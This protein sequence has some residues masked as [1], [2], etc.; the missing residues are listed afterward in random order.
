LI[1]SSLARA[2]LLAV[3][4][5]ENDNDPQPHPCFCVTRVGTWR[6]LGGDWSVGPL[7]GTSKEDVG[8]RLLQQLELTNTPWVEVLRSNRR[9]LHSVFFG[10]YGDVIYHHGAGFRPPVA[11]ADLVQ[12]DSA[13]AW[14][15]SERVGVA[16]RN[17][18]RSQDLFRRIERDDPYWLAD[19]MGSP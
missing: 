12:L 8:G 14:A 6:S 7:V 4:R 1:E 13:G 5:A 18:Q 9:D 11:R 16:L 17:L 3:R 15:G 2:P 10:I 19:L